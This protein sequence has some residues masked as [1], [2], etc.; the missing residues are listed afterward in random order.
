MNSIFASS[1][2]ALMFSL[3]L[4]AA[5][6][7]ATVRRFNQAPAGNN[8]EA[9]T[10]LPQYPYQPLAVTEFP[11]FEFQNHLPGTDGL[12]LVE[13][14]W[15]VPAS[16]IYKLGLASDDGSK[17]WLSLE[18]GLPINLVPVAQI[19]GWTSFQNYTAQSQEFTLTAGTKIALKALVR[20]IGSA[21][22]ASIA[23]SFNGGAF[24]P[25]PQEQLESLSYDNLL[26]LLS[27]AVSKADEVLAATASNEGNLI[28]QVCA[29]QR[30]NLLARR[31]DASNL[32]VSATLAERYFAFHELCKRIERCTPLTA[33]KATRFTAF[34]TTPAHSAGNEFDNA[35]D[36]NTSSVVDTL[37]SSGHVGLDLGQDRNLAPLSIRF[38][39]RSGQTDRM[40]GGKFQ[41]SLDGLTWQDLAS[42][43]NTPI[44][45]WQELSV[46][47]LQQQPSRF[48][49]YLAPSGSYTNVAE[50][51]F[52][53]APE[54]ALELTPKT[55]S[56][57]ASIP[58]LITLANL[59]P[60]QHGL[61]ADLFRYQIT[62]LPAHG[63]LERDGIALSST[64]SFTQA[65]I[66]AGRIAYR[67]APNSLQDEQL[68]FIL[69]G[70]AGAVTAELSLPIII[71]T[72]GDG[73]RDSEE[74]TL[75]TNIAQ[76][77]T[78]GDG[79]S[80][81]F[82]HERGLD[83]LVD[84]KAAALAAIGPSEN[85][86]SAAYYHDYTSP[87][88]SGIAARKS[89]NE[90]KKQAQINFGNSYYGVAAGSSKRN[91]VATQFSGWLYAPESGSYTLEMV[92]DDGSRTF[93]EGAGLPSGSCPRILDAAATQSSVYGSG[94][95]S[96]AID[97]NTDGIYN[98]NSVTHT[99][100]ES[101]PWFKVA[102]PAS[103]V[104]S[105]IVHNREE[106]ANRLAN[107]TVS[108]SL[109]GTVVWSQVYPGTATA[110]QALTF[111]LPAGISADS[112]KVQLNGSNYL[113]LA[114]VQVI[115]PARESK[116]LDFDGLH[117]ASA[118]TATVTLSAGLHKFRTEYFEA[119]GAHSCI[120]SW[121]APGRPGKE[122]IPSEFFYRSILAHGALAATADWDQDGLNDAAELIAGSDKT[123]VD[124]DGDGI[125]DGDEALA[126]F[127]YATDPTKADTDGDSIND[128]DELQ[129]FHSNPL[130][131]D[132]SGTNEQILNLAPSEGQVGKGEWQFTGA[133]A[134]CTSFGGNLQYAINIP[135]GGLY[136]VEVLAERQLFGVASPAP[137]ASIFD[138]EAEVNGM[139][140]G[141]LQKDMSS[142]GPVTFRFLS[143][144]LSDDQH[145]LVIHWENIHACNQ[146][147]IKSLRLI[148]PG[149]VDTENRSW[150]SNSLA[151]TCTLD[152]VP[153]S[154]KVSPLCIEGRATHLPLMTVN[155]TWQI[156]GQN[157]SSSGLVRRGTWRR[158]F[159][160]VP[161]ADQGLSTKVTCSFENNA[162]ILSRQV[163]WA[164]TN[165]LDGGEMVI[166]Q[167]DSLRLNA[168]LIDDERATGTV[169]I[170]AQT[171]PAGI[172]L[173]IAHKFDIPG[174]VTVS[175]SMTDS[176]GQVHN[177]SLLVKV[178]PRCD[179]ANPLDLWINRPRTFTWSNLPSG[180]LVEGFGT[181][182]FSMGNLENSFI[183]SR[184]EH[185]EEMSLIARLG[186]GGP[187]I[188]TVPLSAFWLRE[189]VEGYPTKTSLLPSGNYRVEDRVFLSRK[190]P[191]DLRI[192]AEVFIAGVTTVDGGTD[193]WFTPAD[194]TQ[195]GFANLILYKVPERLGA[196]CHRMKVYQD[197]DLVGQ[198]R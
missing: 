77:D 2:A 14:T 96:R 15:I 140:L 193:H 179:A 183:V 92:S 155:S 94:S 114:E 85:G 122:V 19:T 1:L 181:A 105:V 8:P 67:S 27:Q 149:S 156:D 111:S 38:Y 34:G 49:R 21:D 53:L 150:I 107:F 41:G 71:D 141:L 128:G 12:A 125:H 57:K 47:T 9:I 143:P 6:Q 99:N 40:S 132:F 103:P 86:L 11:K 129:L 89:P 36:E 7:G 134:L 130:L 18:N 91:Y 63:T 139:S 26:G 164:E 33:E 192:K 109:N 75:G 191:A 198:R 172:D 189:I 166:R 95:P 112:V 68:L 169:S 182:S 35:F 44:L 121:T 176:N 135:S 37:F 180:V 159:A 54:V 87:D 195:F 137:G 116:A 28:G 148:K 157:N 127:G 65:E 194:F 82:E 70:A 184:D 79:L 104:T 50:I 147:K 66:L 126:V 142:G 80:D 76:A 115:G 45:A 161:L 168:W 138:L 90:V 108:A 39:P 152:E 62:A 174:N 58:T 55:L 162:R 3:P 93:I 30:A 117:G 146:L 42:I 170:G 51:E 110:S 22:H 190:A 25:I 119:G 165:V 101:Q 73:L 46:P 16:G 60:R 133:E 17:L 185:S 81:F 158:W 98:N 43:N 188:G 4:L 160:D 32:P 13:A 100:W 186:P 113:S 196:A 187:I 72:D 173:A 48:F 69:N 163:T 88:L 151:S 118:K 106:A 144:Y 153:A 29:A 167:G 177:G 120:L 20:D 102:F 64:D 74:S 52:M 83:P 154:S 59:D 145:R 24:A 56:S 136:V 78:D 131:A 123:K 124:T 84:Q 197:A 97:G 171:Q 178:I 5:D 61:D 10:K 23:T 31:N 175:S